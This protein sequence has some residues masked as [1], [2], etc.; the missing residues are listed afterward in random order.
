MAND[1]YDVIVYKI[2]VYYYAVMKRKI[3]F[4]EETLAAVLSKADIPD[5][6][7]ADILRLMQSEGLIEGVRLTKAWGCDY[8]LI[9]D[10]RDISI[11]AAGIRYL[12][13]NAKM[14]KIAGKL[15]KIP[16]IVSTLIGIA[17][18]F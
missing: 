3:S 15:M 4:A 6:Y 18:P 7:L 1:D 17:K 8:I 9:S 5:E 10:K 13:E 12:K 16:G 14:K 2:L 11:T